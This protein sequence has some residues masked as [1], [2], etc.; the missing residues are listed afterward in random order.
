MALANQQSANKPASGIPVDGLKFKDK[1]SSLRNLPR[2]FKLVWQTSKSLTIAN[3]LLRLAHS[4]APVLILYVGKLI[5]DEVI[6]ISS[7]GSSQSHTHLWLLVGAEFGLA[8]ASD[9]LSRGITLLDS[10]LGDLF[11]NYTSVQIM[12]HAATLDL[13]QFENSEFYDKLERA[14]QQTTGRTILLIAGTK[15]GAGYDYDGLF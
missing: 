7:A 6:R 13:D 11:S 5:I 3:S 8:I 15:P 10:L 4:A 12:Q 2:F 9:A 14:R 1:L